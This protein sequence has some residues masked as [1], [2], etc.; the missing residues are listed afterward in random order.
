MICSLQCYLRF[1]RKEPLFLIDKN[2]C[3]F[4]NLNLALNFVLKE[5]AGEG[6]GSITGQAEVITPDQ[7]EYLWQKGFL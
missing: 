6:I 2:G 3:K 7:M 1:E 4:R 5:R